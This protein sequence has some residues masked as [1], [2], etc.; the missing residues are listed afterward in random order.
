MK[1]SF[2]AMAILIVTIIAAIF[3]QA[4]VCEGKTAD[5]GMEG[6][7]K[8]FGGCQVRHHGN[9]IPLGNYRQF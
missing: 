9:W 7:F 1:E 3:M 5:I 8:I 4:A 2:Q 6:R